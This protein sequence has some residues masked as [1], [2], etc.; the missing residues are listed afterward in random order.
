MP[1]FNNSRY[2]FQPRIQV[3][4]ASGAYNEVYQQ[5][6]STVFPADHPP[7]TYEHLSE[8]GN[9]FADLAHKRLGTTRR[10]WLIADFNPHVFYPLDLKGGDVIN[11]PPIA[12]FNQFRRPR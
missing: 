9:D 2:L 3:K 12:A 1:V 8:P 7:G 10:W 5:R 6:S 4:D 11:V